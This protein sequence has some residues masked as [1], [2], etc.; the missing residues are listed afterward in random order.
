MRALRGAPLLSQ[1]LARTRANW[2]NPSTPRRWASLSAIHAGRRR[3]EKARPQ[4]RRTFPKDKS[5]RRIPDPLRNLTFAER[6]KARAAAPKPTLRILKGKK[7]ITHTDGPRPKSRQARFYDPEDTFGKKSLVYKA[8]TGQLQGLYEGSGDGTNSRTRSTTPNLRDRPLAHHSRTTGGG[9]KTTT[10]WDTLVAAS[11]GGREA[12]RSGDR[13]AVPRRGRDLRRDRPSRDGRG[14]GLEG[15][16]SS[17]P[18]RDNYPSTSDR[19][20]GRRGSSD[21]FTQSRYGRGDRQSGFGRDDGRR[22]YDKAAQQPRQGRDSRLGDRSGREEGKRHDGPIQ[23]PSADRQPLSIPYSTAASQFLYGKSVVEAALRASRRKLYKLY[24]YGGANRQ[25]VTQD[26]AVQKLAERKGV[27]VQVV[28]EDGL[29]LM[30]KMSSGRPHNGYVLEASPLPQLPL[31]SLGPVS[32]DASKP[33]FHINLAHQSAEDAE[34]NGTATF[35][36]HSDTAHKP[37]VVVLDQILDPGNFGAILRTVSFLG[38][39]AVAVT[40]RNS[41]SLTPVALKASAGASEALT[42]FSVE[43]LVDFLVESKD[44]GWK[45]YAAAPSLGRL[46]RNRQVD[47]HE[48]QDLDPLATTP[49]ILLMGSEGE[50]LSRQLISKADSVVSIPNMSGSTV[51]DSLNVSV[52]TGLVCSA[53]LRGKAK[54]EFAKLEEK[55]NQEPALW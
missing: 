50:G 30:E 22:T 38:A 18:E 45:V 54:S 20:E 19:L 52:A 21:A 46:G 51:V 16:T 12:K 29:R 10:Q 53:F 47:V 8:K 1:A 34:I 55:K 40:K 27:E 25:N 24:V 7:D 37:L 32:D 4:G 33:G 36:P 5:E 35:L 6:R 48:L 43:Q 28:G 49:C 15:F 26:L 39:T 3:E 2:W 42:V 14:R 13:R 23:K 9:E 44:S 11:E 41:A 31:T 17:R